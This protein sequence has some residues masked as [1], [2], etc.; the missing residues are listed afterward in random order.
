MSTF[1]FPRKSPRPVEGF[2]I[3]AWTRRLKEA[4]SDLVA[5]RVRTTH[6]HATHTH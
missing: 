5:F 1:N 2:G 6:T 3:S 4:P